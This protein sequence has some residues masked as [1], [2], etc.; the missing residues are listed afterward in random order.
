MT[1][2]W[3]Q[4]AG[5]GPAFD[6]TLRSPRPQGT[7]HEVDAEDGAFVGSENGLQ[8]PWRSGGAPRVGSR[9]RVANPRY[10]TTG[11]DADAAGAAGA[12]APRAQGR[13]SI[14]RPTGVRIIPAGVIELTK[15]GRLHRIDSSEV[16]A[17]A[18]LQGLWRAN[19]NGR[20]WYPA[21][22]TKLVT[23]R[24]MSGAVSGAQVRHLKDDGA[25]EEGTDA[26]DTLDLQPEY[27]REYMR[28]LCV[29][30]VVAPVP[31]DQQNVRV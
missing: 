1:M 31:L 15:G 16:R 5:P 13:S 9:N 26:N 3:W 14:E 28:A 24:D 10:I 12:N 18:F 23:V 17:G 7:H 2:M 11:T 6:A 25:D 27:M 4:L 8:V 22:V 29:G 20:T 19:D 21:R 30:W